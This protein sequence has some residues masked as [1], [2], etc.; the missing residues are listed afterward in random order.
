MKTAVKETEKR[1][2]GFLSRD[3]D[4]L[5]AP[6]VSSSIK[7]TIP[8]ILTNMLSSL[9]N[10]ADVAV[11]GNLADTAAVASVGATS[12]II[13]L[14]VG[15]FQA[16]STG[17]GVIL[18]RA[19]GGRDDV[20]IARV[21]KTGYTFSLFLGLLVAVFGSVFA[22][23][24][25]HVTSCPENVIDGA[26][27][28]MRIYMI[29]VPASM[30]TVFNS[31]VLRI[32]GD[33]VR[34]FMYSAI[35]GAINV[36]LNVVLV[37]TTG[38]AVASVAIATVVA[39]YVSAVLYMIKLMSLEGAFKL[40][41]LDF[42]INFDVLR[43]ILYYGVPS[44][45]S[46]ATFSFT[47]VQV[48]SA[49]NNYGASG[50]SGNTAAV[51]IEAFVFAITNSVGTTV[52]TFVG[53]CIGANKRERVFE[54][55]K[56]S[57]IIWGIVGLAVSAALFFLGENLLGIFI[58]G[59]QDAIGFGE[60][61]LTYIAIAT[62][63]HALINVNMGTLVGFGKTLYQM[64]V[65]IIGVCGFRLVW[66]L[67]IYPLSPSPQMLYVCYP[68]SYTFVVTVG[69]IMVLKLTKQYKRGVDFAV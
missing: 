62:T 56:K 9:Y 55:I 36:I 63:L 44:M 30:F 7:Y 38:N 65:N 61:R 8:L 34:P 6:V 48:Q 42:G 15:L 41:P 5:N 68:I 46:S 26:A 49:I 18:A 57:Y 37:L 14:L 33:T 23:P 51:N 17:H 59:E 50:I 19:V 45:V 64:L 67:I 58:P 53:Q 39:S 24:M 69:F 25:L 13:G 54:V 40:R 12:A 27:L 28:Y 1:K 29:S 31:A 21:I 22:I 43:K 10:A 20:R 11:V 32:K 35:S 4:V 16:L 3:V 60:I 66:M 52:S 2:G 47:N